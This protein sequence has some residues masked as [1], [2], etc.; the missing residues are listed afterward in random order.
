MTN[1]QQ[2][3]IDRAL[4]RKNLGRG[5]QRRIGLELKDALTLNKFQAEKIKE[6]REEIII[7]HRVLEDLLMGKYE[8][9]LESAKKLLSDEDMVELEGCINVF[10]NLAGN[11]AI[12]QLA[13][14]L[15]AIRIEEANKKGWELFKTYG[16]E[17]NV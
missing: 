15:E 5:E 10:Q 2:A 1:E 14:S 17:T 13:I 3:L 16:V 9:M 12:R 7:S 8:D 6:M 4:S 11:N